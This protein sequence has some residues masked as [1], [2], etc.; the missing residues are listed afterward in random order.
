MVISRTTSVAPWIELDNFYETC[1]R[2]VWKWRKEQATAYLESYT[3][4]TG[5]N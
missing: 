1:I 5:N 4:V 2:D 3:S